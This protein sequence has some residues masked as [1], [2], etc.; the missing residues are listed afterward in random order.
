M[1]TPRPRLVITGAAGNLGAKLSAHLAGSGYELT[2]LDLAPGGDPGIQ[3]AD[4]AVYDPAWVQLFAG[5]HAVVHLAAEAR[6]WADWSSL[7]RRNIDAM[8]NVLEA[9]V[10][11]GVRRLVFASSSLVMEG[12][13]GTGETITAASPP[14]PRSLYGASKCTGER[15]ARSF[16]DR[17]GLSVVCLRIGLVGEGANPPPRHLGLWAQQ[18]WLSDRDLCQAVERAIAAEDLP[19]VIV[20]VMSA[21][22]GMPWD[23][24]TT[25]R[26]LGYVPR[27]GCVPRAGPLPWRARDWVVRV[28]RLARRLSAGAA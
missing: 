26:V 6:P 16:A 10:A 12:H 14:L 5:A 18:T 24:E 11:G 25:R 21:N 13:R 2:R 7:Q 3:T 9:A 23:I 27:D 8:L 20:N 15:M 22:Q 1:I 19:F 28:R 4:L 17:D